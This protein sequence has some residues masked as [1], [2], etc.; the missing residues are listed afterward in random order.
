VHAA[1]AS[2]PRVGDIQIDGTVL[3][4]TSVVVVVTGLLFGLIPALRGAVEGRT[5]A[6]REGG[7]TTSHRASS[8]LRRVL[9]V[10]ETALAVVMLAGAGLM[11]RSLWTLQSADLGFDPSRVLTAQIALPATSYPQERA[12]AFYDQVVK[13]LA[14]APG[15]V[16]A[17]AVRSLPIAEGGDRWSVMIDNVVLRNI[18]EAPSPAPQQVTPDYFRVMGIG[19]VSGRVFT[20]EDR[21]DAP[22]VAVINEQ[23][24]RELWKGVNPIG[25][26]IRMFSDSAPWATIVGVVKDV[27]ADGI[28]EAVP[29]TMYFPHA[30]ATRSNYSSALT[31]SLVVRTQG[32][33]GALSQT[34]RE[35]V[36]RLDPSVPVARLTTMDAVVAESIES[37]RFST[38]LLACFAALALV[39][40]GIGIYGVIAFSVSQ[41]TYEIGLRVALGAQ[42]RSVAALVLGQVLAM[43]G[44]GV[45]VGLVGAVAVTQSA[46]SMLVGVTAF[47]IPTLLGAALLIALVSLV[48]C[49]VPVRRALAIDPTEALR[50]D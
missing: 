20:P 37:R 15:V 41:R 44:T 40:A 5:E 12:I 48:A 23:L 11:L 28:T 25:R 42:R 30:Q 46:R 32:D 8:R 21:L 50:S 34:V 45:L 2:L 18:S 27:R 49:S 9:V 39:L 3:A 17:A 38:A 29:P 7:K 35:A 33:P 47:D 24:A 13:G 19:L 14:G 22:L 31:M 16:G 43:A 4:F 1:P 10:S 26:T 6:L 36:R